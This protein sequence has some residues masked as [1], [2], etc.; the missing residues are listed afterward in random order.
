MGAQGPCNDIV[1]I[2]ISLGTLKRLIS[3][4]QMTAAKALSTTILA[5]V[6]A[7]NVTVQATS[8][9]STMSDSPT[10]PDPI[11]SSTDPFN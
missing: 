5:N 7:L 1:L 6:T 4:N 3:D 10:L 9:T 8:N 11:L 2:G